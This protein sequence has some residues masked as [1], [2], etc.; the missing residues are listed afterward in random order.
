MARRCT[1]DSPGHLNPMTW[2]ARPWTA[3]FAARVWRI[4]RTFTPPPNNPPNAVGPESMS[5]AS[6]SS[7]P[8]YVKDKKISHKAK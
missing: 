3:N 6:G 2:E 7:A 8:T 4:G 5:S 1:A